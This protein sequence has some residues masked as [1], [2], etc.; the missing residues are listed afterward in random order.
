MGKK[1]ILGENEDRD[2]KLTGK[3]IWFKGRKIDSKTIF[4]TGIAKV[5]GVE[6]GMDGLRIYIDMITEL[7][8]EHT[9]DFSSFEWEIHKGD[10]VE[11]LTKKEAFLYQ[12]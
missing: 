10:E 12:L 2:K 11:I 1:F 3:I 4:R 5:K 6:T 9:N 8:K 7:S